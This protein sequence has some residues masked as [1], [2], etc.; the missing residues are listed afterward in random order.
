MTTNNSDGKLKDNKSFLE[1]DFDLDAYQSEI[2]YN[3][4]YKKDVK[5]KKVIGFLTMLMVVVSV[6]TVV[7]GFILMVYYT[8][9]L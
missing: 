5:D 9:I 3:Y 2:N 6:L 7:Q 8:N 4:N 1:D